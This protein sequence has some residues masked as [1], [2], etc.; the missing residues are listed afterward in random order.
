VAGPTQA[1]I[2]ASIAANPQASRGGYEGVG[3]TAHPG[4]EGQT[5]YGSSTSDTSA[6]TG[7]DVLVPGGDY[8]SFL[9]LFGLPPEATEKIKQI[10]QS[11]PDVSQ[12]TA[13][14]LGY[15]R[16]TDW[17]AKTYPGIQ[18]GIAKGLFQNEAGYRGYL[19]QASNL[20]QQFY[21]RAIG[22]D[23]FSSL[24]TRGIDLTTLG[25]TLQSGNFLKDIQSSP[26]ASMLTDFEQRQVA[27]TK[28]G[29][30][31]QN[32]TYL[33]GL[34]SYVNQV[35]PIYGQYG[36]GLSREMLEANYK[37]GIS[38]DTVGKQ[39]QGGAFINANRGDIQQLAGA[40]NDSGQLSDAQ[41]KAYG[42]EQSGLD[43]TLGA[44]VQTGLQ[45]AQQRL[46]GLLQGNLAVFHPGL[47]QQR[48]PD[49][50]A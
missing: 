31:S 19:N 12:A 3:T 2:D 43:S 26:G 6:P 39:L 33:S 50:G 21:G 25:N 29:L 23:E 40:F 49:V 7:S 11:T 32:G 28:A 36:A 4:P 16:G 27:A 9:G 38:A 15:I 35:A 47:L 17:Y 22:T 30:G 5:S 1:Q 44:Q 41:L 34:L 37:N 10:F 13:L 8:A 46:Q 14:A 20:Y 48:K 45:K 24:V 42:E 18:E